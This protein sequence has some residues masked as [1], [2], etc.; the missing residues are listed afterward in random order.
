MVSA[1]E[2]HRL[3]VSN[4]EHGRCDRVDYAGDIKTGIGMAFGDREELAP[5][6]PIR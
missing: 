2:K 4:L 5:I 6:P 3:S 1:Y